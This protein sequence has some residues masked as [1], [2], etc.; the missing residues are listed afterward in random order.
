MLSLTRPMRQSLT[1]VIPKTEIVTGTD[2]G[3]AAAT[4]PLPAGSMPAVS[5][6]APNDKAAPSPGRVYSRN[7]LISAARIGVF[8]CAGV[9]LPAFLTHR[10]PT[11]VFG[12]WTLILQ[13]AG[14][15]GYLE[16]GIQIAVSKYVAEFIASGDTDSCHRHA[17]AGVAITGATA[18]AGILLSIV[19]SLL[20]P[21]LFPEIPPSLAGDVSRGV[22]LVGS[23]AALLLGTSAFAGIFLGLQRYAVPTTIAIVSKLLYAVLLIAMVAHGSSLTAMGAGV[24]ILNTATALTQVLAWRWMASEVRV[25]VSW[26]QTAVMKRVLGYCAVLGLWTAGLLIISGMDTTLVGRLDFPETAF[27]AIAATPL[28]FLTMTLQAGLNP[29]MPAASALSV[30]HSAQQMGQTLLRSTRYA[31][32]ILQATGLPLFLF[33]FTILSVWVGPSYARHGLALLR[34]L[35]LAHIVRNLCAPYATMVIAVGMQRYATWAG[36]WEAVVNL[37]LSILLGMH[38][39]AVGV[40]LGTLAGAMVGVSLHFLLSM[41][42]TTSLLAISRRDLLRKGFLQS[43]MSLLPTVAILPLFWRPERVAYTPVYV[44]IWA[45]ATVALFWRTNL[46]AE[47]RSTLSAKVRGRLHRLALT[48]ATNS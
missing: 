30:T 21:R 23:S 15:V 19:F 42:H 27:Y 8:A 11:S 38:M 37:T 22:L 16:F 25:G 41:R 18:A 29:L 39:G 33:G 20:I 28:T 26:L 1:V 12:A 48:P 43:S 34:I 3:L 46:T 45:V 31:F 10:M 2:A 35:V 47:E 7:V 17:S 14:Y 32:L 24:A 4:S 36:L 9:L 5:M 6:P 13:V 40:A 44:G